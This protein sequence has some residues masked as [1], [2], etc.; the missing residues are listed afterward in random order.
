MDEQPSHLKKG[1]QKIEDCEDQH[2]ENSYS[3][4]FPNPPMGHNRE[5]PQRVKPEYLAR[6]TNIAIMGKTY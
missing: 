4:T 5:Y 6:M 2:I 3:C 1:K